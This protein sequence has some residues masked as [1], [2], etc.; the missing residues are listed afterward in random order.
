MQLTACEVLCCPV[1][2][3]ALDP[4]RPAGEGFIEEGALKCSSCQREYPVRGGIPIFLD[5]QLSVNST[6]EAFAALH[7]H[8][9]QKILQREW[10]DRERLDHGFK[11]AAYGSKTLFSYLLYYQ[12]LELESLL[13][14]HGYSSVAN[15]G[16]GHGFELEFLSRF[17][18][19]ILAVDIS[20]NSLQLA[21]NRAREL[22]VNVVAVCADAENLPLR[23]HSFDLVFTHHSLHHLPCPVRGLE[24]MIRVSS[25]CVVLCEPAK[26]LTRSVLTR[27]GIKPVVEESG[28]SVYEFDF[29]DVET[30]CSNQHIRLRSFRK[31]LVTGPADEPAWFRRLDSWRIT[32][33]LCSAIRVGNHI[34]GNLVGT[35]CSLLLEKE[36]RGPGSCPSADQFS[37]VTHGA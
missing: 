15:I 23:D 12:M 18:R 26:G 34:L 25:Q 31:C 4:S 13:A 37:A 30:L 36:N 10:H 7:D 3:R 14:Q 8:N 33:V 29:K 11:R 6:G 9:R 5:D 28:N 35:K 24:E 27:L 21:L 17:C 1:C 20:W 19:N 2:R 22:G 32:P 16:A